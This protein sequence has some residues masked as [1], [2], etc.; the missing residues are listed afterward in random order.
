MTATKTSSDSKPYYVKV[1]KSFLMELM[2]R[3]M[4]YPDT[5][6]YSVLPA[7][8]CQGLE[9]AAKEQG[10]NRFR[11]F[12]Q[13]SALYGK[14]YLTNNGIT[15]TDLEHAFNVKPIEWLK[16]KEDDN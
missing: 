7:N 8:Q 16:E 13:Y 10:H 3:K 2:Q 9:M 5:F 15:Y 1:E 6:E 4:L 14:F 12:V 11:G